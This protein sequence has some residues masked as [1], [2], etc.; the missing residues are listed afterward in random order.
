M[1]VKQVLYCLSHTSVFFMTF[2]FYLLIDMLR[3]KDNLNC[4]FIFWL[5]SLFLC[6]FNSF[7]YFLL[8]YFPISFFLSCRVTFSI[9]P[10][11]FI[12]NFVYYIPSVKIF[13]WFYIFFVKTLVF[14]WDLLNV[15]IIA[16]FIKAASQS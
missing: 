15:C 13:I 5:V 7:G 2:T 4:H 6:V 14:L 11:H 1:L 8:F 10:V 12:F 9:E 3:L 16:H